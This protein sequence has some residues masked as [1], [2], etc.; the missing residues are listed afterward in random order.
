MD[1]NKL[2]MDNITHNTIAKYLLNKY[3]N[4]FCCASIKHNLWYEFN[5]HRW[6]MIDSAFSLRNLISDELVIEYS[7]QQT[8]F[9]QLAREKQGYD[10]ERCFDQALQICKI[11]KQLQSTS[12]KNGVIR[13]CADITYDPNFLI[14]LDENVNL[15]CFEN[16]VYDLSTDEFRNG[17]PNDYISLCT[18]YNY[19][20]YNKNDEHRKD[21]KNIFLNRIQPDKTM[22]K[23]LM[24][25]LSTCLS[26]LIQKEDFYIFTGLGASGIS[27]LMELMR[28]TMGDLFEPMDIGLLMGKKKSSLADMKGVRM[29]TFDNPIATDEINLSFMEI[30]TS[31]NAITIRT[32]FKEPIYFKPQLKPFLMCNHLPI[33]KSEAIRKKIKVIHFPSKFIKSSEATTSMKKNGLGEN[34]F[35]AD[36]N[37]SEY[38]PKWKQMFMGMLI[39][40]YKKYRTYGLIYPELVKQYMVQY[41]KVQIES[42]TTN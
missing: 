17:R 8:Y 34:Q 7:N 36:T 14:N 20:K 18:N 4:T 26:G 33:I 21:I 29:C 11:I 15:I 31:R 27:K 41:K 12:F 6:V 24:T 22:R 3:K 25:L 30:M 10:K 35:W 42:K 32:L 5:N 23:F 37:L 28:Y 39:K 9:Y 40:Y 19:V 1:P 13:E 38:F 2:P 16:G